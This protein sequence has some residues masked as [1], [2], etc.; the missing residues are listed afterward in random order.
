MTGQSSLNS[1]LAS[2]TLSDSEPWVRGLSEEEEL[3]RYG[4]PQPVGEV[5][6]DYNDEAGIQADLEFLGVKPS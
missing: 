3:K 1:N 6:V 2:E 5:L 4:G